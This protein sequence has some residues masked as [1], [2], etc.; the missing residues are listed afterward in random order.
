MLWECYLKLSKSSLKCKGKGLMK[1]YQEEKYALQLTKCVFL[2]FPS[3]STPPTFK[4]HN[5]LIV[6]GMLPE[7]LQII[8]GL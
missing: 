7:V 4:P 3:L 6:I 2:F 5:F 8:L 1:K